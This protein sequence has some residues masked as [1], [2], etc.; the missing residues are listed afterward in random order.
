MLAS[1]LYLTWNRE[2]TEKKSKRLSKK[3]LHKLT[4]SNII[5]VRAKKFLG[6]TTVCRFLQDIWFLTH[7]THG[8]NNNCIW[9][10]QRNCFRYTDAL[11]NK[12][13]I[14]HSPDRGTN[15]LDI[16]AGVF[17]W[18]TFAPYLF[19]LSLDYILLTSR[20][21]MKENDFILKKARSRR[22]P[23]ETMKDA[24]YTYNQALLANTPSKQIPAAYLKASRAKHW[25]QR[26]C[27]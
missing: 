24:E 13:A 18:D 6:N 4:D 11:K 9:S 26:E 8:A 1:Q 17:P 10:S 3:S 25:L 19:I 7:W 16:V 21:L 22:Y 20:D 2:N 14:F 15:F 5:G 27:N 23:T 12:K